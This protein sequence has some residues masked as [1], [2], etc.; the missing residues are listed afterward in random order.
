MTIGQMGLFVASE[1]VFRERQ[2]QTLELVV[3][4]PAPY[5]F[6]LLPRV[7]VLTLVGLI[8]FVE[9]WLLV[10][11][12]FGLSLTVHHPGLLLATLLFTAL[13]SAGTAVLTSALFSLGQQVR[14][15]QNAVNG[16]LYLLGGVLV[17]SEYLP[18]WLEPLSPYVFFYWSAKLLRSAFEPAAPVQVA[19]SLAAILTLGGLATALGALVLARMLDRL[20]QRGSLGLS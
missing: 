3:A 13:A 12:V 19:E 2:W 10:R 1:V 18:S 9:S 11:I 16:P 17:P 15:F 7:M 20:R 4:T 8:G 14:T 5:L 6:V